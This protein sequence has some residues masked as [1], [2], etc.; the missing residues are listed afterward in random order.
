MNYFSIK[1]YRNYILSSGLIIVVFG[2]FILFGGCSKKNNSNPVSVNNSS[3]SQISFSVNGGGY[4]NKSFSLTS[5][6]VSAASYISTSNYT[7]GTVDGTSNKTNISIIIQFPGNG[8]GTFQ[9]D[10]TS[11]Q[12]E[13][14][15]TLGS[16]SYV[17]IPG[18]GSTKVTSYGKVGS[19]IKGTFSGT[20]MG[21]SGSSVDTVQISN[22]SF[23]MVRA[24]NNTSQ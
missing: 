7:I 21:F 12:N 9:W 11:N 24:N 2:L 5:V 18:H 20:A 13:V 4:N 22:G 16:I 23:S 3:N 8:T 1:K 6:G 17:G 15:L 14:A 19:V 10:S